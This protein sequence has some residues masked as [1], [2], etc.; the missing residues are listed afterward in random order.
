MIAALARFTGIPSVVVWAALIGIAVGSFWAWGSY[1]H[2]SGSQE[3]QRI[4]RTKWEDAVRILR[5][6]MDEE[7]RQAQLAIDQIERDYLA[8]RDSDLTAIQDLETIISEMEKEDADTPA[9]SR[10]FF[11]ER[12][13]KSIGQIGR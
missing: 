4:E 1:N 6:Q 12:L 5:K 3:G 10:V 2:F 8:Q 9:P 7:R 11:P 13:S